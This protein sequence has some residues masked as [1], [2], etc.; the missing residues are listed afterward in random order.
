MS[1]PKLNCINHKDISA[2]TFDGAIILFTDKNALIDLIPSTQ[3]W[4]ELDAHFGTSVQLLLP[5]DGIPSRR[6]IISPTGSLH[7]DFDD[8]RRYKGL[9][10]YIFHNRHFKLNKKKK[11][12]PLPLDKEL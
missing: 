12:L 8:V 11:M 3:K 7:Q 4:I 10:F 2:S 1:L 9:S 5:E 6:V